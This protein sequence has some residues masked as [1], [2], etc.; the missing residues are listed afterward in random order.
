YDSLL[1]ILSKGT[2][3]EL[4][5]EPRL[6]TSALNAA[7]LLQLEESVFF[8]SER[9]LL[10]AALGCER[11][12]RKTKDLVLRVRVTHGHLR[13]ARHP[14]AV[15]HYVGDAI[16]SAEAQLDRRLGGRLSNRFHME[17]YAGP[18]GTVEI[19]RAPSAN[20]PGALVIGLGQ[21]G[22]LN[23]ETLRKGVLE[24]CLRYALARAE[25]S[26]GPAPRPGTKAGS[27]A[28][29]GKPEPRSAAISSLLIGVSAGSYLSIRDSV[30]AITQ[31]VVEANRTLSHRKVA[32]DSSRALNGPT[33][34]DRVI[35]DELEFIELYEE[36]AIEAIHAVY[37]LRESLE[38]NLEPG[39]RLDLVPNLQWAPGGRFRRPLDIYA[40]GWWR[41]IQITEANEK[42][43]DPAKKLVSAA[44]STQPDTDDSS[45]SRFVFTALTDRARIEETLTLSQNKI[46]DLLIK[47][48]TTRTD[49]EKCASVALF[50]LLMPNPFK[51]QARETADLVLMVDEAAAHFPW[52]LMT[53]RLVKNKKPL[54]VEAGMIRQFK[55]SNFEVVAG[56][57]RARL[58]NALVI[59]DTI[60]G[61]VD[62]PGAQRE[63]ANVAHLLQAAGYNA[64]PALIKQSARDVVC[65]LFADDYRIL[66]IA[67]HGMFTPDRPERTGLVL[68]DGIFL[69]PL[70]FKQIRVLP[71]L[72]FINCCHLGQF[73]DG[74]RLNTSYP[75]ALA[76]SVA[77]TL[78]QRGVKAV[79]A[80]G[81]A[82]DDTAAVK[83]AITFYQHLLN[84]GKFGEAVKR[85]R[86]AAYSP[87][88][89]TWGAY[90]CYGNPDFALSLRPLGGT[91]SSVTFRSRSENI[92]ELRDIV[93]DALDNNTDEQKA[94]LF[95]R[96][97]ELD[98]TLPAAWRDG[99]V[100]CLLGEAY[101][102]LGRLNEACTAL[103][104]AIERPEATARLDAVEH[105]AN[106]LDRL[107]KKLYDTD[108]AGAKQLWDNAEQFLTGLN[109]AIG[110]SH[111]RL[112]LLGGLWKRRGEALAGPEMA[113]QRTQAFQKSR[114]YYRDAYKR[115][116][117]QNNEISPYSGVNWLAMAHV[118]EGPLDPNWKTVARECLDAAQLLKDQP[119][120]WDRTALPDTL[121]VKYLNEGTLHDHVDE[122]AQ[123]YNS[124]FTF[125]TPIQI[126]SVLSQIQF[127]QKMRPNDD[128][129]NLIS[130]LT[131]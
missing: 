37:D 26:D 16:V 86:E 88:S 13:E 72:V 51:A 40:T 75:E 9:D 60:S 123:V 104:D 126:D 111:E 32:D 59:G 42:Q 90:Q 105:L 98:K 44:G 125:G 94:A 106:C 82:V 83:F 15:G 56:P 28:S 55:T 17:T 63:A 93:A 110:E 29:S 35:I 20:P 121:L 103:R 54:A 6:K 85:A 19:V 77:E 39:E 102:H 45:C 8:P 23:S 7:H 79:V 95:N 30:L 96:V 119:L 130:K 12:V 73:D 10:N 46:S 67:G 3:K 71:E 100:L 49:F 61:L 41:R 76:G 127:I 99:E 81:W 80:A 124:V 101:R 114:D 65:K 52:E 14:V 117:E 118:S 69:S 31:A 43:S 87:T 68:E 108:P 116:K 109:A 50:E 21:V 11:G 89:N 64:E 92:D 91:S 62:L 122:L 33:L 129:A 113:Q 38:P 24:A 53:D 84:G 74:R 57:R 34:T 66:H 2:A 27:A 4:L 5:S 25:D 18:L 107:A 22:E 70:E 112:S 36:N 48:S 120:F 58:H 97:A 115:L 131:T 78:I 128:L 1:E 47:E